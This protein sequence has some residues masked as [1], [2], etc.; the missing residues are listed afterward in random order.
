MS[1][2]PYIG[3]LA[4]FGAGPAMLAGGFLNVVVDVFALSLFIFVFN[5]SDLNISLLVANVAC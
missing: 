2:L 1:H 4:F 3:F 5:G